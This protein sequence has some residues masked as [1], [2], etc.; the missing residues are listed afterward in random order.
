M[1]VGSTALVMWQNS[2]KHLLSSITLYVGLLLEKGNMILD[3]FVD[4]VE[5]LNLLIDIYF[6]STGSCSFLHVHGFAPSKMGNRR[7]K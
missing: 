7:R 6:H 2:A 5:S 1:V 4:T 3:C